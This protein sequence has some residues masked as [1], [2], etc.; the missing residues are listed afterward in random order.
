[1]RK[2]LIKFSENPSYIN[3][4]SDEAIEGL[5]RLIPD[6]L[7]KRIIEKYLAELEKTIEQ[8]STK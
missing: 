1:L 3:N 6:I 8:S 4:L 5:R 2:A 7:S